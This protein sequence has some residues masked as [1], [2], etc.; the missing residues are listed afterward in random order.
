MVE[1]YPYYQFSLFD[2]A[3]NVIEIRSFVKPQPIIA[4]QMLRIY[5]DPVFM[6]AMF[7]MKLQISIH[8]ENMNKIT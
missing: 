7:E 8:I 5:Y 1:E 3:R 6:Y 4:E 2:D